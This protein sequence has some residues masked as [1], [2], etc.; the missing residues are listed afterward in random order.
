MI[1]RTLALAAAMGALA[2]GAAAGTTDFVP[3]AEL[4]GQDQ[5]EVAQN[6]AE[7]ENCETIKYGEKCIYKGGYVEIVFIVGKADWF[8]ITPEDALIRPSS[9]SQLGLPNDQ[10]PSVKNQRVIHWD[11]LAKLTEVTIKPPGGTVGDYYVN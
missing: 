8:T 7:P 6:F 9:I 11:H 4:A 10:E 2:T 1:K 5:A 3:V